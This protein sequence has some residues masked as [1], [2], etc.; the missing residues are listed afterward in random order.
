MKIVIGS[1]ISSMYAYAN[2]FMVLADESQV[3]ELI[4]E[5]HDELTDATDREWKVKIAKSIDYND[6]TQ[7]HGAINR[8]QE[9][10]ERMNSHPEIDLM[11]V[12][13]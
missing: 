3:D 7:W 10:A 6:S 5:M 12:R 13:T 11:R 9:K 4:A 2:L 8:F 1:F